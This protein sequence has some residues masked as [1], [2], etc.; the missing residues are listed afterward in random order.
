MRTCLWLVLAVLAG[1][2]GPRGPVVPERVE[3][4]VSVPCV[5]PG[6]RP[7]R[8]A[9]HGDRELDA[10]TDYEWALAVWADRLRSAGYQAHLEA[11]V[12]GCSRLGAP[13]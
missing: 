13:R 1:C 3:V 10:M 4:P 7:A 5:A 11:V 9:Y 12:E 6:D 8:P 2:A